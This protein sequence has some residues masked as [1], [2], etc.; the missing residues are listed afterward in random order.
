MVGYIIAAYTLGKKHERRKLYMCESIA[1]RLNE[2]S[3]S[4]VL[5][6]SI[7]VELVCTER[8]SYI[9]NQNSQSGQSN[10]RVSDKI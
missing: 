8:H 7:A 2:N 4:G 6:A 10:N 1:R 9:D 3:V 5:Y